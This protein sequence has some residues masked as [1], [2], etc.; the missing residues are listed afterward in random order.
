M[1]L[2]STSLAPNP[3]PLMMFM[4]TCGLLLSPSEPWVIPQPKVNVWRALAQSLGQDSICLDTG[5]AEDPMS[6]CLVGIP[7]SPGEFPVTF[8]HTF[9]PILSQSLTIL[10][11][12]DSSKAWR[13]GVV[14]LD[15]APSEP[16]ELHLLGSANASVCFQFDY[17]ITPIEKGSEVVRQSKKEYQ[18]KQWCRAV[19][20]ILGP[21]TTGRTPYSLPRGV[22]LICGDRAWAGIPSGLVGGPC[23]FG[24]LTLFTPN[25]TQ[26]INWKR[27]NITAELDRAKR[28]LKGLTEDCDDEITH[29]SHSK[30]VAFT[31]LLPWVSV[32]K[33]LGELGRLECWV[34]KQA[35]LTS[36]ALY[37]L[38]TDEEITRKAT[39]QNRAA[40]DF[41]L[42]LHH[43]RCEEFEGLCCLNLSSRA[44]D[45][46]HSIRK[47]QDLVHQVKQETS[48]WLGDLFKGWGLSGWATS[49]IESIIKVVLSLIVFSVFVMVIRGLVQRLVSKATS[50][51]VSHATVPVEEHVELGDLSSEAGEAVEEEGSTVSPVCHPWADEPQLEE[52]EDWPDQPRVPEV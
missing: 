45:A 25:I 32:A 21:T 47:L 30:S 48:D 29:W 23:T 34:A 24:R 16:T 12:F 20:K 1:A 28:D 31:I 14:R 50:P 37:D 13:D 39:L 46:R 43:H 19:L 2:V 42:L 35:N 5:A 40:I 18:A 27:T 49:I 41:L 44:E 8:R 36:A 33:A 4:L 6:S 3:G 38:L 7:S 11:N 10:P 51:N 52:G 22:F 26:I 9:S 17:G 15:P